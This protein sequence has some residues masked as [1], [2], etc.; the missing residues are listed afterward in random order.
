MC[1]IEAYVVATLH[2][3]KFYPK[4]NQWCF[5]DHTFLCIPIL[6]QHME[7]HAVL[8]HWPSEMYTNLVCTTCLVVPYC[9][10]FIQ[11]E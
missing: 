1:I 3:A 8:Q 9:A 5:D 7:A 6:E 4:H 10:G 2:T 11:Y